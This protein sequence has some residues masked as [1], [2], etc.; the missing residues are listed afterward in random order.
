MLHQSFPGESPLPTDFPPGDLS[1]PCKPQ[2]S[3]ARHPEEVRSASCVEYRSSVIWGLDG[4][5]RDVSSGGWTVFTGMY[6]PLAGCGMGGW[7]SGPV[8][9]IP[10]VGPLRPAMCV[11]RQG[12]AMGSFEAQAGHG[13]RSEDAALRS[14]TCQP[15]R[16]LV[17]RPSRLS[18]PTLRTRR[19]L[20]WLCIIQGGI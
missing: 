16:V 9:A 18:V 12:R 11:A 14:D 19:L 3:L 15:E 2:N 4:L 20:V 5:H 1:T 17:W 7:Y 10:S 13:S 6:L 8:K